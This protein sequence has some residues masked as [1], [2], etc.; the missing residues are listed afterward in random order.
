M[1]APPVS[2][3]DLNERSREIF[4]HLVETYLETGDPVGSRTLSKQLSARLS[5]ATVRNVMQDLEEVGLLDSPHISAGRRPTHAGLRLFVDGMLEVGGLSPEEKTTIDQGFGA[6][7]APGLEGEGGSLEKVLDDAGSML[8]GLAQ[9]ASLVVAPTDDAAVKHIDFVALSSAQALVVLVKENGEIENRLIDAPAGLT[10][11]AMQEAA[12][13]L[14]AALRGRTLA[15]AQTAL[16]AQIAAAGAELSE[17]AGRLVEAGAATWADRSAQSSAAIAPERLIVRGRANLLS[18]V[19][20]SHDVERM[21]LLFEELER[22]KDLAQLIDL[23]DEAAGV[24]VFIGA[25]NTLFSLT[26]S[27][28]V[29]S[30]YMNAGGK[31]IGAIGVIG[32]TRMNYGRIVPIVD[33]TAKLVGRA[34]SGRGPNGG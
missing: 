3:N 19:E 2:L 13:Y 30:P 25:E 9:A 7:P 6:G 23:T 24:R 17:I 28:L 31:V 14:N 34:L 16:S 5:A 26:G 33:Y 21:R 20:L 29:I 27:S 11:S 4:R 8:S 32:P 1:T 18:D 22:K 10:P 12:N 15:E